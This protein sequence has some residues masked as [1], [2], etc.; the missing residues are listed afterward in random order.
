MF[1]VTPLITLYFAVR[2]ILRGIKGVIVSFSLY[3][4]FHS[5]SLSLY[6]SPFHLSLS[7]S[8]SLFSLSFSLAYLMDVFVLVFDRSE[9]LVFIAVQSYCRETIPFI[10]ISSLAKIPPPLYH[11]L[12]RSMNSKKGL[13]I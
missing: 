3:S 4:P 13:V 10:S 11:D 7:L 9:Y 2:K 12:P 5:P 6:P 8:L 1:L